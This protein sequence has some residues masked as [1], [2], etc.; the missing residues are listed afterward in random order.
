MLMNILKIIHALLALCLGALLFTGLAAAL[1]AWL[2]LIT[3]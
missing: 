2:Q 3:R 1:A